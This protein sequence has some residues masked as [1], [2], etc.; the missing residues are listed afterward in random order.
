MK[1]HNKSH[2][3]DGQA[4]VREGGGDSFIDKSI[5]IAPFCL[6]T[7]GSNQPG[8]DSPPAHP[9]SAQLQRQKPEAQPLPHETHNFASHHHEQCEEK[10][11]ENQSIIDYLPNFSS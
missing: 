1:E 6:K 10:I 9:S 5:Q 4:E 11:N 3:S 7:G 8:L 2:N